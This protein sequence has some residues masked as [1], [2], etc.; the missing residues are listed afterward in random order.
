[1]VS[2]TTLQQKEPG[3]LGNMADSRT[4]QEVCKVSL[5]YHVAIQSRRY[6]E[7]ELTMMSICQGY[8]SQMKSSQWP[9]LET[10]K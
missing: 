2:N 5:E 1:M 10:F 3:L 8:R 6:K 9:K 7:T 4:G